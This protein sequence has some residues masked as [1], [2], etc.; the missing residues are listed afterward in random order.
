LSSVLQRSINIHE[1]RV[2]LVGN[3]NGERRRNALPDLRTRHPEDDPVIG[4]H[5]EH[6]KVLGCLRCHHH[7]L[8]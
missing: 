8:A 7:H 5:F 2:D 1:A 4:R 3:H 6:E